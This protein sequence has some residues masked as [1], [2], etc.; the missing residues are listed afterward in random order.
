MSPIWRN[1]LHALHTRNGL[2]SI[3]QTLMV[4]CA[5]AV[6]HADASAA[7][8]KQPD[9]AQPTLD[10]QVMSEK[11]NFK[12]GEAVTVLFF[13][14]N[15]SKTDLKDVKIRLINS[16]SIAPP[17][18]N[19]P[20]SLPLA[21]ASVPPF[22]SET[23]TASFKVDKNA[24]FIQHKLLFALDYQWQCAN[25]KFSSSQSAT[26]NVLVKREFEEEAKGLPGGT[27]ALLYL[28]LPVIPAILVYELLDSRRRKQGWKI[29][30]FKPEYI[31]PSFLLAVILAAVLLIA[32]KLDVSVAYS[33]PVTFA[34]LTAISA[35]LGSLIPLARWVNQNL[36][37]KKQAFTPDDTPDQYLIKVLSKYKNRNKLSWVKGTANDEDWEGL[38][39]EQPDTTKVLGACV[40]V[41]PTDKTKL[42]WED[43]LAVVEKTGKILN[44]KQLIEWVRDKSVTVKCVKKIKRG[45]QVLEQAVASEG[46]ANFK[47]SQPTSEQIVTP[48]T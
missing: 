46:L 40:E 2:R 31:L 33:N 22:G 30:Q 16:G 24:E 26:L 12:R 29:P 47:S 48:T 25:K 34:I 27:A 10:F 44:R 15:K 38:E 18:P 1:L 35:L 5:F 4:C 20:L 14:L 41:S 32:A 23:A 7:K 21:L 39:L 19:E 28:I 13:V 36:R 17:K 37:W 8:D 11:D 3:A 42:K 6:L 43:L 9:P 45:G